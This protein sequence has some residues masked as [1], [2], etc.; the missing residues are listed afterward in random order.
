MG[1]ATSCNFSHDGR[2]VVSGSDLDHSVKVWDANS[3]QIVAESKGMSVIT[4]PAISSQ[5]GLMKH[6]CVLHQEGM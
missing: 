3:G 4:T 2:L 1:I 6:M 5:E